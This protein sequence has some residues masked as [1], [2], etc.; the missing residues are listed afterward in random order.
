MTSHGG[1]Y[2]PDWLSEQWKFT[3]DPS[4][5]LDP[6]NKSLIASHLRVK[7]AGNKRQFDHSLKV[8]EQFKSAFDALENQVMPMKPKNKPFQHPDP[9]RF[10][11]L[12]CSVFPF[13]HSSRPI[14]PVAISHCY[15]YRNFGHLSPVKLP[16]ERRKI[17]PWRLR[18]DILLPSMEDHPDEDKFQLDSNFSR[19]QTW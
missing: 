14:P 5:A 7:G 9:H 11:V 19:L 16:S 8:L 15:A 18:L 13:Y 10:Q 6:Q 4:S 3:N 17:P 2:A 1:Q 12:Q